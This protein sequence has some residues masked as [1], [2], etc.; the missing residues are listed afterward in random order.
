MHTG[1]SSST[2]AAC[3]RRAENEVTH[4]RSQ[5]PVRRSTSII[6]RMAST[7]FR[8]T[9]NL[10]SGQAVIRSSMSGIGSVPPIRAPATSV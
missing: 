3:S 7:S 10:R 2:R 8:S 1:R 6:G 4:T 9:L 5:A